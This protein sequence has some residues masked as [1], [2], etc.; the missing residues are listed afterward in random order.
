MDL[1][2]VLT[3]QGTDLSGSALDE[4]AAAWT[5]GRAEKGTRLVRQGEPATREVMLLDGRAVAQ[6]VDSE[7][8]GVCVGFYTGPGFVTPH[9]A[10]SRDGISLVTLELTT[11][12]RFAVMPAD[13]LL[14]MMVR[15]PDIRDWANAVLRDELA[16]KT[17]REWCLAAL[18]GA[19][20]LAWFRG[21]YTE[22][23][24]MFAHGLVASFLGMTP[25]SLS[26]LRRLA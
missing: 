5:P 19:E 6:I 11:D 20:R 12:A 10:R 26:R 3:A 16:R 1:R 4:L 13:R 23:E 22:H 17:D 21:R 14:A 2:R 15:S 7:G 25:V 8:R 24:A 9:I 18:G